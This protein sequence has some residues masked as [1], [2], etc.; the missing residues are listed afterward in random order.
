M[1][2]ILSADL[3]TEE[4]YQ[5][6]IYRDKIN[7]AVKNILLGVFESKHLMCA[8][9]NVLV[10]FSDKIT[11]I[12]AL[13]T[14]YNIINQYSFINY[15]LIKRRINIV[16][17]NSIHE[18]IQ[19]DGYDTINLSIDYFQDSKMIQPIII[20]GEDSMDTDFYYIISKF[21]CKKTTI[22]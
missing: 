6:P 19:D 4:Y 16:P 14:L 2:F 9:Y 20:L 8:D 12:D 22:T 13:S 7:R 10:F 15:A 11:D 17:Q 3:I 21:I 1:L 18:L 5:D